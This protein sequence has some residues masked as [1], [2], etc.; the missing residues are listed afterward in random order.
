M[1]GDDH[2]VVRDAC[3]VVQFEDAD[4]AAL[5]GLSEMRRSSGKY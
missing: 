3:D 4:L 5:L 1:A 2:Q